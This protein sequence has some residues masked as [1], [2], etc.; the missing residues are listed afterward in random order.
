MARATSTSPTPSNSSSDTVSDVIVAVAQIAWEA[1][2][3]GTR[4]AWWAVLFPVFSAPVIAAVWAWA[5]AGPGRSA[6]A[7]LWED[8]LALAKG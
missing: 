4:L 6:L 7:P 5:V 2:K 8:A 3:L 1:I